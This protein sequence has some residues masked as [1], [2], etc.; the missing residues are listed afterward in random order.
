MT[1]LVRQLA[2]TEKGLPIEIYVFSSDQRWVQYED[3]QADIFDH[4]Y[5]VL[6]QFDLRPFQ[7]PPATTSRGACA[8]PPRAGRRKRRMS[9]SGHR[10][11]ETILHPRSSTRPARTLRHRACPVDITF[12][13]R[14]RPRWLVLRVAVAR[15]SSVFLPA[16]LSRRKVRLAGPLPRKQSAGDGPPSAK[17]PRRIQRRVSQPGG[18]LIERCSWWGQPR[19]ERTTVIP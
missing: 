16:D 15:E 13:H 4:I 9:P 5:A 10:R 14:A 2:P 3:I 19:R 8:A 6:P 12:G 7:N 18:A 1:F 17:R 11:F